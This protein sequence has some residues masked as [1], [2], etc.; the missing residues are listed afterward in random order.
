[1]NDV[2]DSAGEEETYETKTIAIVASTI[3]SPTLALNN[4]ANPMTPGRI[5]TA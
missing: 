5:A 3:A 2:R 4:N 1:M